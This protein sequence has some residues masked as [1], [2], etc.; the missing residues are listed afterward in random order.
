MVH[1]IV[2]NHNGFIDV[3]STEGEGTTFSLYLPQILHADETSIDETTNFIPLG[4]ERLL[5][6]DDEEQL[7]GMQCQMLER[8]GYEVTATTSSVEAL[9]LFCRDP[10]SFDLMITDQT[11]P[12]LTGGDLAA[13]VLHIRDDL[14]IIL[15]TGFSEALSPEAASEIGIRHYLHKSIPL[16]S[17]ARTVRIVLNDSFPSDPPRPQVDCA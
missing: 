3:A 15:C 4:N 9:N 6:V 12:N 17:L 7:L 16:K 1:G 2:K 11:M 13:Q 5:L 10:E 14:P 8:L